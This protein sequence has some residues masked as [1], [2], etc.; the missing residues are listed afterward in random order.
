MKLGIVIES[1]ADLKLAKILGLT[2]QLEAI[3]PTILLE[4]FFEKFFIEVERALVYSS[5]DPCPKIKAI[6]KKTNKF[7]EVNVDVINRYKTDK[8]S[9]SKKKPIILLILGPHIS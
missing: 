3:N 9:G 8:Q 1:K 4:F 6:T 2:A 5:A 7:M